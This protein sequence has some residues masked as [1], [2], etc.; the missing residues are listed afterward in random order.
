MILT[1]SFHGLRLER[2]AQ[3]PLFVYKTRT[4]MSKCVADYESHCLRKQV[5]SFIIHSILV[6]F[7]CLIYVKRLEQLV[8][9]ALY[10]YTIISIIV[11]ARYK[12]YVKPTY[13]G[14]LL[15]RKSH[16]DHQYKHGFLNIMLD[17]AFLLSSLRNVITSMCC[18]LDWNA[19]AN[20]FIPQSLALFPSK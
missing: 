3:W 12:V 10:K 6:K 1:P 11:Y 9:W 17:C 2:L 8:M 7:K 19:W 13:A 5:P 16:V 20:L 14:L 4:K 15:H 18:F